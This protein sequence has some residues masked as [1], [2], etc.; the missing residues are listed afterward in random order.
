M[1]H[2]AHFIEFLYQYLTHLHIPYAKKKWRPLS[3]KAT[4]FSKHILVLR[5]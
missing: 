2:I 4:I 1:A 3:Q 5:D